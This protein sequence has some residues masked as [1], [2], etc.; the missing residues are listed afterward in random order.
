MSDPVPPDS[1]APEL[2]PEEAAAGLAERVVADG[3]GLEGW[4]PTPKPCTSCVRWHRGTLTCEAYPGRI[5]D[6]ILDGR[7]QHRTPY[8]GDRGLQYLAR[9]AATA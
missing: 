7:E 9:D 8:P 1:L 6:A 2:T 3:E 4:K 5:P